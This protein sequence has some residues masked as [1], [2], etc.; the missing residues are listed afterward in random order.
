MTRL[1]PQYLAKRVRKQK[2][3]QVKKEARTSKITKKETTEAQS[4]TAICLETFATKSTVVPR[5]MVGDRYAG[6][7][8]SQQPVA[9]APEVRRVGT[10]V[11]PHSCCPILSATLE[12]T[13]MC[14][15]KG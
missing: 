4:K 5:L 8:L 13:L 2:K 1:E 7:R 14:L 12:V 3:V 6:L 9:L 10:A 11:A 15:A